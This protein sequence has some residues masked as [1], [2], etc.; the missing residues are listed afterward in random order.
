MEPDG[1]L[2]CSQEPL[3]LFTTHYNLPIP[4]DA[5]RVNLEHVAEW[6][7]HLSCFIQCYLTQAINTTS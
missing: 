5:R 1:S 7:K 3:Y 4:F 6:P 2:P